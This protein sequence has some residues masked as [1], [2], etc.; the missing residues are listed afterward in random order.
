MRSRWACSKLVWILRKLDPDNAAGGPSNWPPSRTRAT[1]LAAAEHVFTGNLPDYTRKLYLIENCLY[2]VDI[3]SI[4]VQ[5]A[6][7]RFF[8]SLV[9]DQK[10]DDAQPNRG[11]LPLPNLETKVVAAN[12][13]IAPKQRNQMALNLVQ[14]EI[15]DLEA[16]LN[17]IRHDHF[18]ARTYDQKKALRKRDRECREKLAKLLQESGAFAR[19]EASEIALWN[20]YQPD[21]AAGFFDPKWMFNYAGGFDISIGNPPYVRQEDIKEFK[22]LFKELFECFTGVADLYVYFYE[23][24][25]QIL[26]VGGVLSFISSN[27]YFRSGYGERLRWFLNYCGRIRLL[28][29]F[30]DAPVFTAIAYPSIIIAQKT[31][32]LGK[33]ELP[34]PKR[35]QESAA[36]ANSLPVHTWEP[37]RHR[38]FPSVFEESFSTHQRTKTGRMA[39][40]NKQHAPTRT[41]SLWTNTP[42]I[43][44]AHHYGIKTGLN[45]AF[46]DRATRIGIRE[47]RAA[48]VQKPF[49]RGRDVK[50]WRA[51]Y[52]DITSSKSSGPNKRHPWAVSRK[53]ERVS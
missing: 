7:L 45:E 6:K 47:D 14:K 34:D 21:K 3:Q 11:V 8:I 28:L 25:F 38:G 9:V 52:A 23:R 32:A 41:T 17:R 40:I 22:P 44:R 43:R 26:K 10:V 48:E 19:E 31:R 33:G 35:A 27:K 5:I 13:L 36:S 12:S 15:D 1:I 50:R 20:P 46:V 24:S 42:A 16:V 30:G 4:A 2:G 29:D 53:A 37:R 51:E 49:L 18:H 39:G